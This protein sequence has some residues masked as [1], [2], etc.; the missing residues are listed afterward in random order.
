MA[1][2]QALDRCARV[3]SSLAL[4]GSHADDTVLPCTPGSA[5]RPQLVGLKANHATNPSATF[6]RGNLDAGLGASFGGFL[7]NSRD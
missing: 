1:G 2:P 4:S 5:K 7:E 3:H 6:L